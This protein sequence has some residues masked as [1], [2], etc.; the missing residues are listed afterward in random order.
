M[1]HGNYPSEFCYGTV[2][3]GSNKKERRP[4]ICK[5]LLRVAAPMQ[6]A[7]E[8]VAWTYGLSAEQYAIAI[9]T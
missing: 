4:N 1:A 6:S 2:S 5:L 9:W 3:Q 8:A 7:R